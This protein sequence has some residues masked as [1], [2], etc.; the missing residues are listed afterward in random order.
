MTV[1]EAGE[2]YLNA[3][4]PVNNLIPEFDA[5]Q[6]RVWNS[7]DLT[8]LK[9]IAAN[10]RDTMQV[11]A[12][13][14]SDT[15]VLWPQGLAASASAIADNY[16]AQMGAAQEMTTVENQTELQAIVWPTATP[17]ADAA[18]PKIRSVLGLSTDPQ[19]SCKGRQ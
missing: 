1:E 3:V 8:T 7:G 9:T 13:A 14:L 16:Y 4:C 6:G 12:A 10:Y 17:E 18:G 11:S 15:T 2:Y 19:E 5:E